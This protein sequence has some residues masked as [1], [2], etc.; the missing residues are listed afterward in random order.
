MLNALGMERV[1]LVQ[2]S[3]YGIDNTCMFNALMAFG[4]MSRGVAVVG[5][6]VSMA[7]LARLHAAGVRALRLNVE[8]T[9]TGDLEKLA[10]RMHHLAKRIVDMGWHLELHIRADALKV[11][12]PVVESLPVDVVFDHMG[13]IP[14][15]AV[16]EH[17]GLQ[18]V[19]HMLKT[20]HCWVKLSAA[21]RVSQDADNYQDVTG[22][23][24]ALLDSNAERIVWGSD[25]PHTP[26][27]GREAAPDGVTTPFR[28]IDT[29]QLLSLLAQ[30]VPDEAMRNRILVENPARLYGFD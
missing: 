10:H 19:Q 22:L 5:D 20:G 1:V 24:T 27:H 7:Q 13:R 4:G 8:T 21:Y 15:G 26:A 16:P 14:A 30:W 6:Q 29:G 9:D 17:L 25:W 12:M 18:A 3:V 23:V 11:L 2:P 28:H